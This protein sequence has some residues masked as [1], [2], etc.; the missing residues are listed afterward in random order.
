MKSRRNNLTN[1]TNL[2]FKS[3]QTFSNTKA[4][5]KWILLCFIVFYLILT[6]IKDD[7]TE[8]VQNKIVLQISSNSKRNNIIK[9][10]ESSNVT[11]VI[12]NSKDKCII[13]WTNDQLVGRCFGLTTKLN[14]STKQECQEFCC[15]LGIN[16][17][18]WQFWKEK[19]ICKIGD[20]V[21]LGTEK[22]KTR[23]WCD[24]YPPV[25]WYSSYIP[26]F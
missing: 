15:S 25:E 18:T 19:N 1:H 8:Q 16:C 24:S 3:N 6:T 9:D 21:R 4:I 14:I 23:L 5:Y 17:I 2:I 7:E 12:N 10:L 13:Q 11:H 22:G 20:R 26:L